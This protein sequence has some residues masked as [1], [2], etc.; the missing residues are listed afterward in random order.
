[1]NFSKQEIILQSWKK[2]KEHIA[3]WLLVMLFICVLNLIIS[4]VQEKILSSITTQS[5]L[6]TLS[7]Y[8]FQAGINL[9]M[10]GLALNIQNGKTSSFKNIFESFHVL[11]KYILATVI[12]LS[13][14]ILLCL[15]GLILFM[16][17]ITS[18]SDFIDI[19]LFERMVYV[20]SI[21][22]IIIPAVYTSIRFQ[23]YNYFLV[24]TDCGVA[25]SLKASFILTKG[26][27]GELFI[28]GAYISLII[29]ISLIPLMLGLLITIPLSVMVNAHVYSLLKN[30]KKIN[31]IEVQQN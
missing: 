30:Y 15:P 18:N 7:A 22:L 16:L 3:L 2:L 20:I 13:F 29:L 5:I 4:S 19:S 24:E 27:V 21:L 11:L 26:Y 8:L 9:G 17:S 31:S 1:M 6:F 25:E 28:L 23:F 12:L 10:I 14:I